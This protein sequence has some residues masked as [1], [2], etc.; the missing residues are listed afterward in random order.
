VIEVVRTR[1]VTAALVLA[2]PIPAAAAK[3]VRP[4][5]EQTKIDFLLGE[6][7]NSTAI[8]IRNGREYR[9]SRAASHLLTKLNFAGKRVQTAREFILGIAS[10]SEQTGQPY[11]IRWPDGRR[12]RLTEWLFERLDFYEK[13][14]LVK[15]GPGP[16]P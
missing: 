16:A 8:F 7:K 14:H 10:H 12:L 11:E 2:L 9:S 1:L 6:V 4:V 5:A 3:S 13:E 15:P